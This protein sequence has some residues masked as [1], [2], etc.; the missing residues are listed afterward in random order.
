VVEAEK[1]AREKNK[2]RMHE[3][4][5]ILEKEIEQRMSE[6]KKLKGEN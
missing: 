3:R 4:V 2:E 6:L 1:E 5:Q